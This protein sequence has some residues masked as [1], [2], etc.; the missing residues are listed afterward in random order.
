[1]QYRPI[2]KTGMSASVIGLGG[3]HLDNKPYETVETVI[4]A[5][6]EQGINIMD[7]FMPG[8]TVRTNIGQALAGRRDKMLI[9]GHICST[10]IN[11]QYDTSRDL[12]TAK[13]YFED[14][15][16]CLKTDYIDIGMLFF[17]DT[18]KDFTAV[19]E[20]GIVRYAQDLKQQGRIRAIGVG[21]HNPAIARKVVE[22]GVVDLLMFSINPAF[23][24]V[25]AETYVIDIMMEDKA[26]DF[27]K[28]LDRDRASLYQLCERQGI[29]ITVMKT[30]G[31][32]KLISPEH[33][34]FAQPLTVAQCIHYALTRP[35][36]VSALVGCRS[37]ED[38][39]EAAAYLEKSDAERDYSAVLRDFQG[40]FKGHCVYCNHCLPCPSG[41]NI[42]NVHKYLD[43][44][45]LDEANIPPG[46]A[47]HYRSLDRRA[48]DCSACGSC[49]ERCPFSVP[50]IANMKKAAALLEK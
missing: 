49:E 3:E 11:E 18:E 34:P 2:G 16:R 24:M 39:L 8:E 45:V 30:L 14:L 21:S 38:V 7:I 22:T 36:V 29:A 40:D 46:V 4:H 41:I 47:S 44:A 23:D 6:L 35:A 33:T 19:F 9:Q 42:A 20:N 43:I 1:M 32:G 17:V 48:S 50:V 13:K 12:P 10:D 28:K 37:R 31:A 25:P 26:W 5:A 27:E 15:F